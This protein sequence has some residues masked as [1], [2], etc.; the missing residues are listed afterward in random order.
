MGLVMAFA[1]G[2]VVGARGGNEGLDEVIRSLRAI[3]DSPEMKD[4]V[5]AVRAHVGYTLASWPAGWTTTSDSTWTSTARA[6]WS[7][8]CAG[9]PSGTDHRQGVTSRPIPRSPTTVPAEPI[10]GSARV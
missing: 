9:S 1:M 3:R 7:T 5:E 10:V 2:Y 4:L 8:R 6:T